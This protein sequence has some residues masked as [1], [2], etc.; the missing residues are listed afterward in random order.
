ML[1]RFRIV[2]LCLAAVLA[3]SAIG[4]A[5]ASAAPPEFK[6]WYVCEQKA[7]GTG[8]FAT[9]AAC[10][11]GTPEAAEG[12]WKQ[13]AITFTSSS[14]VSVLETVKERKVTCTSDT[15]EG[16]LTGSKTNKVT[17]KFKGCTTTKLVTLKCHTAGA[18][19]EEEIVVHAN[20]T[21][22]YTNLTT[23]E[24]SILLKPESGETFVAFTCTGFLSE[25]KITVRDHG[26][27][28]GVL[29]HITPTNTST[30][31]FT[32]A[33]SQ[34]KGVQKS[35]TKYWLDASSPEKTAYLES[36]GEGSEAYTWEQAGEETTDTLTTSALGEIKA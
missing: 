4:A 26:S 25:E 7:G 22:V 18:S 5:S 3:V 21:L 16:V 36:M 35:G 20:S 27:D 28:G 8:K 12:T 29:G 1:K 23:K 15:N 2:G 34:T 17:V 33:F 11:A 10:E 30:T 32:L 24:T 31:S 9:K 13:F 19:N 14:G 6:P